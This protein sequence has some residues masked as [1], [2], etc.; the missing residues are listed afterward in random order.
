MASFRVTAILHVSVL[1]LVA[2]AFTVCAVPTLEIK[3]K[4]FNKFAE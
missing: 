1:H 2:D 4:Y 3:K